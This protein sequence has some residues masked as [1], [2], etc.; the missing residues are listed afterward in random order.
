MDTTGPFSPLTKTLPWGSFDQF[1]HETPCTVKILTINP[2]EALSLQRH[3]KRDEFWHVLEGE[4]TLQIGDEMIAIEKGTNHFISRNS[5]HRVSAKSDAVKIL[6][7]SL[8]EFDESDIERL[9]D[10]YGRI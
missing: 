10:K 8:G 6:E 1:V 3:K 9:E 7:I 5:L 4:G 2:G